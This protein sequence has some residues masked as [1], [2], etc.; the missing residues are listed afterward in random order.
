ML[1]CLFFFYLLSLL[2]LL[3]SSSFL[4]SF[5][6]QHKVLRQD[7]VLDAIY[8]LDEEAKRRRLDKNTFVAK[9]IIGEVCLT[10]YNN[11]TYKIGKLTE[12]RR[13]SGI[14]IP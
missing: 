5:L 4:S 1:H 14:Y 8:E 9:K 11:K 2:Y 13:M 7:S 10:R 12:L 3:V 6:F